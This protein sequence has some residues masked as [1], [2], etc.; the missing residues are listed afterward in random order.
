VLAL[1]PEIF[2]ECEVTRASSKVVCVSY[3]VVNPYSTC[4]LEASFVVQVIVAEVVVMLE[5]AIFVIVGAVISPWFIVMLKLWVAV[6]EAASLTK[7]VKLK[8]LATLGVPE[9]TPVEEFKDR[10][11]GKEP[12]LID[13]L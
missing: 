1:S 6:A 3:P 4:E 5:E 7:T 10:P 11:V 8:V 9:I 13:Q 12:E 2:I